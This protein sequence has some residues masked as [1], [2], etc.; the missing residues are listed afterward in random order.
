MNVASIPDLEFIEI[1]NAHRGI[2]VRIAWQYQFPEYQR[3]TDAVKQSFRNWYIPQ[4]YEDLDFVIDNKIKFFEGV[5]GRHIDDGLHILGVHR[6]V[7][8]CLYIVFCTQGEFRVAH[9]SLSKIR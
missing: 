7:G 4:L 1:N 6:L 3:L 5:I 2:H 9:L 8:Q